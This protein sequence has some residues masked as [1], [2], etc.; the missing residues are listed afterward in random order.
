MQL[1]TADNR[2][3]YIYVIDIYTNISYS[4]ILPD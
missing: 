1:S 2:N 3:I 4:Y